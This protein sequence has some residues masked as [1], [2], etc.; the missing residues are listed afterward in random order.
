[1]KAAHAPLTS[2]LFLGIEGGGTRTRACV[3]DARGQKVHLVEA[4]PAQLQLLQDPQLRT[5]LRNLRA[6][7]PMPV[8]LA[9]GLAGARTESDFARIRRAAGH[10]WPGVPCHATNDLETAL[11][12]AELSAP[13]KSQP[14]RILILSGTG[15]CCYGRATDGTTA[16]VG[17]WG[18]LLGDRGSAYDISLRACR[19][20]LAHCDR[21]RTVTTLGRH[22]LRRLQINSPEEMLPWIRTAAKGEVAALA[23]DVFESW[24]LGDRIA[25]V[26]VRAAAIELAADAVACAARL[27]GSERL[28]EFVLAGGVLLG[29][30]YYARLVSRLVRGQWPRARFRRLPREGVWGAVELARRAVIPADGPSNQRAPMARRKQ[31]ATRN[32]GDAIPCPRLESLE[33]SPTEDRNPRSLRLDELPPAQAI[34]LMLREDLRIPRALLRERH[35]LEQAVQMIVRCMRNGGRLFY[36]GAG[37]SGR[38]GVLDASE[39]PPTFGTT[40]DQVQAIIA[41]GQRAVWESVEGAE[42]DAWAGADAIRL[43]R[44][45]G[46]DVV[47]GIA[48]G[49]RTPFVWG[50]FWEARRR[51]A[52]TVLLCF[53][54]G[55]EI[56]ARNRPDLV[57]APNVG[58]EILTGSTRLKAGT[59]TKLI[60]NLFTTLTMVQLG[61]VRSNLMIDL[62]PSNAK[63]RD[64]AVRIVQALTRVDAAEA[65]R[66]LEATGWV[67]QAGIDQ[68][69]VVLPSGQ[70]TKARRRTTNTPRRRLPGMEPPTG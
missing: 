7:L 14:A 27:Q 10:V 18:H 26:V 30:P 38:L 49:G 9:I 42:D 55:L 41:G 1:M 59:A 39:C 56:P 34:E 68:L 13:F 22:L 60:L 57:I 67:V 20:V 48:T 2:S 43:R 37:T 46:K 45:T 50:A 35:K 51:R 24:K 64:R 52:R 15:S 53:N 21:K 3:A 12:T 32:G 17:G 58:P 66:A 11:M 4:P 47:V 40:P 70:R 5:L 29:Q 65:R 61:K 8:S 28:T 19:A 25:E 6:R 44:V 69:G 62:N 54:P 63:L 23:I 33:K 31:S 36:V 16:R